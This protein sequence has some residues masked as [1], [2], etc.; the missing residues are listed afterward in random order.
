MI[1]LD[2]FVASVF[3]K[4]EDQKNF[5]GIEENTYYD[6]S[7]LGS[8]SIQEDDDF[9]KHDVYQQFTEEE[10]VEF[11]EKIYKTIKFED[12]ASDVEENAEDVV[13]YESLEEV[14]WYDLDNGLTWADIVNQYLSGKAT[15]YVTNDG[16]VFGVYK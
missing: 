8:V 3:D 7:V 11:L 6:Y 16:E 12:I 2:K 9:I 14:I 15:I 5:F 1:S 13:D 10:I 4:C